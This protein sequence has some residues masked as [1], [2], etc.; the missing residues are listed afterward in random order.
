MCSIECVQITFTLRIFFNIF[1]GGVA[2]FRTDRVFH[3]ICH[4]GTRVVLS[5]KGLFGLHRKKED[6]L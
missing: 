2:H 1:N 3:G 6:L 5:G 4:S